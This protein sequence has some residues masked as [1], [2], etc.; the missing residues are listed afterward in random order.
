M[1]LTGC[2]AINPAEPVSVNIPPQPA[3]CKVQEEHAPVIAGV[4][5]VVTL[6]R[7][8]GQ[9]DKANARVVRCFEYNENIRDGFNT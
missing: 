6:R 1:M 9:L 3:D 2:N 4:D 7:E 8:R 5:K